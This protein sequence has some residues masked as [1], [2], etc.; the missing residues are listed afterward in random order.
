[1]NKLED[2]EK[3][4]DV[5]PHIEIIPSSHLDDCTVIPANNQGEFF[6]IPSMITRLYVSMDV[7]DALKKVKKDE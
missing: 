7:F 5:H 3:L 1:M 2:V 4:L 6:P